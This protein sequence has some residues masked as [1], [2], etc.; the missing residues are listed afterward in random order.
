VIIKQGSTPTLTIVCD[1]PIGTGGGGYGLAASTY[2]YFADGV[3]TTGTGSLSPTAPGI[4]TIL[5]AV[6]V[7]AAGE[8]AT[9]G[10]MHILIYDGSGNVIGH[11]SVEVVPWDI[12]NANSLGLAHLDATV[13]SRGTSSLNAGAQMDLVAAPNATALTAVA[14]AMLD[15]SAGVQ[16]GWTLRQALRIILGYIAGKST[17]VGTT[18]TVRDPQDTKNRIVATV[19]ATGQR[20]AVATDPS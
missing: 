12:S 7:L 20:T 10:Q 9:L 15:L 5:I 1:T 19:D 2:S 4:G 17:K 3:N 11:M 13:S 18:Y 6:V 14:A 8:T 16:T